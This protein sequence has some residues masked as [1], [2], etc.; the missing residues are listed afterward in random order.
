MSISKKLPPLLDLQLK[1][2]GLLKRPEPA[3]F[4]S[5]LTLLE[6]QLVEHL[7]TSSDGVLLTLV[8]FASK[9][10]QQYSSTHA[11]LV[12]TL[13]H[14]GGM[15]IESW[16]EAQRQALRFAAMTM[17]ISMMDLQDTL[18]Q[19]SSALTDEQ[20][21]QIASH[22]IR[23]EEMLRSLGCTEALWLESVRRH[24]EAEPGALA[25]RQPA[26]QIARMIQ[27]ADVFASRISPRKNRAALSASAAAQVAYLDEKHNPDE[28]GAALIKAVGIYP[29]GCWVG[30]GSGEIAMVLKRGEKAHCP[31]VA[32][33]VG[34]DGLPLAMPRLRDTQQAPYGISVSIA[35]DKIKFRPRLDTLL[36]ML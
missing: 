27:R 25:A 31:L 28:A 15:Q 34:S 13:S 30:L 20:K 4:L 23:S 17:N 7:A 5:Q 21:T 3:N 10:L 2:H 16:D 1:L 9:E 22:P 12:T 24:H 8:D 35:P 19:Q 29:P 11:M 26:S 33:L 6:S 18:S 32:A 14:L 36:H